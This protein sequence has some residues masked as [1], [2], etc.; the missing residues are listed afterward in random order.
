MFLGA[1]DR[2]TN[3]GVPPPPAK[4]SDRAFRSNLFARPGP[5][6]KDFR[7]NP[8]RV[9]RAFRKSPKYSAIIPGRGSRCPAG[10]AVIGVRKTVDILT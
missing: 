4:R 8:L 3:G 7:F 2:F 1:S 5:D 9:S 10:S 6:K